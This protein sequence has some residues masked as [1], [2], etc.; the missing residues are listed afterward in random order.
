MPYVK[1]VSFKV[2]SVLTYLIL[3]KYLSLSLMVCFK[4][5]KHILTYVI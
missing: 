5:D 2:T 1:I 4:V 3:Q